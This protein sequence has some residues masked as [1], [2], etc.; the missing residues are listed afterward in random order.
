MSFMKSC[1]TLKPRVYSA[2]L[3]SVALSCSASQS[4]SSAGSSI[5]ALRKQGPLDEALLPYLSP[6]GWE[7]INLTGDYVWRSRSVP[8]QGRFRPLRPVNLAA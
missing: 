8:S 2:C 5:T 4:A 7:H 3:Y 1:H 6:L